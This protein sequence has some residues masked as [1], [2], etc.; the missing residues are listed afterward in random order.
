M[1]NVLVTGG[2][3]YLGSVLVRLLLK[4]GHRVSVLDD[5]LHGG[6]SLL[7][8]IH[9]E[10]FRFIKGDLRSN[11]QLTDVL[12]GADAVVH[13]AAIVGDPACARQPQIARQVNF[14]ASL[15]LYD[16]ARHG[17]VRRFVFASTCSSYGKM[18]DE[19]GFLTEESPLRPV[20]LYAE[21]KVE[22]EKALLA[23]GDS[24]QPAV[25]VLRCSTLYGL[26]PR[27]RFD[28]TVNEFTRDLVT[29]RHLVVFGAQFWRPYIHVRDAAEVIRLVLAAPLERVA[30]QVFNAGDSSQNYQKGHLVEMIR[31]QLDYETQV[32]QVERQ[33]DPRDYRVSFDKINSRLPGF[34][35]RRNALTGA[36]ELRE[37]F[38]RIGLS[39]EMFEFRA[40]TRLRQLE[41]LIKTRQ[42][43]EHFF[44]S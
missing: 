23:A 39:R 29:K 2:A 22:V 44:W 11:G 32:E 40:F 36:R 10:N 43:D 42:L 15:N 8:Y 1:V 14:D 41:Y 34:R 30:G 26:S 3:G 35:C 28:L 27:M 9:D 7:S 24:E 19:A 18:A 4:N 6:H 25:T 5:L 13:L 37:L 31:S 21:T 16:K 38:E 12:H 20:S 17:G 33:E